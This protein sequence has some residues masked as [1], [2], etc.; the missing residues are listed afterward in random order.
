MYRLL[1][2]GMENDKFT[3]IVTAL[4]GDKSV[5]LDH[6][7]SGGGALASLMEKTADLVVADE[8]LADMSGLEFAAKLVVQNP[9]VNCALVSSL[10]EADFH[11]A[12]EGLGILAQLP[13]EPDES[14]AASLV[15]K[16]SVVTGRNV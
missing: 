4:Q 10:G 12:S 6:A 9:V 16:L 2:I 13:P 11:E 15:A 8:Q 7:D 14:H 5:E 1:L 3:K